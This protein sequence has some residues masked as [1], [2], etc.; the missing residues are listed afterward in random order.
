MNESIRKT[1]L[2]AFVWLLQ[3]QISSSEDTTLLLTPKTSSTFFAAMG[4]PVFSQW[5]APASLAAAIVGI[6]A[7]SGVAERHREGGR[8]GDG[9]AERGARVGVPVPPRVE[10]ISASEKSRRVDSAA[11]RQIHSCDERV[12]RHS[13][14]GS[15][16]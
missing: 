15:A 7:S 9:E 1:D 10:S 5:A 13:G 12:S 11:T 4:G 2:A 8:D 14:H 16:S 3:H 6:Y